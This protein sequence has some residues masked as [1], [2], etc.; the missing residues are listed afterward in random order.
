MDK[1]VGATQ[2]EDSSLGYGLSGREIKT[3]ILSSLGGALEYYDFTIY[4]FFA[5]AISQLFFPSSQPDWIRQLQA[6][7][8]FALGWFVRPIGGAVFAHFGDRIGRKRMFMLSI[9]LMAVPTLLI[10]LLPTY[11]TIGVWAPLLLI[12]LRLLQGCAIAGE[13]PGS[14]VFVVEHVHRD[15]A[16]LACAVLFGMLYVGLFLGSLAGAL[17]SR[18]L[19]PQVITAT[20]WRIAFIAGGLFGLVAVYLR[21]YLHETPLFEKIQ[22][23]KKLTKKMPL[24]IVLSEHWEAALFVL[25]L[26]GVISAV[27]TGLFQFL[28]VPLQTLY[29]FPK[30]A[31][32]QANTAA[33]LA[34]AICGAGWGYLGDRI[35]LHRALAIGSVVTL[36]VT[37]W[38]FGELERLPPDGSGLTLR[39]IVLGVAGSFIC[40]A[41]SLASL[42]FPTYVRFTGFAFPYNVG[43]A[44]FAGL[45]PVFLTAAGQFYGRTAAM[46][47]V[48]AGCAVGV[49]ISFWAPRILDNG[50]PAES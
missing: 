42:A 44:I 13:V 10:G 33:I 40:L 48:L 36:V 27:V 39:Y 26:A 29:R 28:Q 21:R 25:L 34:L 6:F 43:A 8:I 5:A 7:S 16:G 22:A 9:F 3:L 12:L 2:R 37:Y 4:I 45:I 31:V 17:S 20:G 35:G 23:Q 32:Y 49:S 30:D 47:L 15:R 46:Y 18:Y 24:K 19:D 41:P 1:A 50:D 14:V 38:F 11:A